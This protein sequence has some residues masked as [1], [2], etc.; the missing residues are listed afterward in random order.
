MDKKAFFL[1][2]QEEIVRC[3]PFP[4]RDDRSHSNRKKREKVE[5]NLIQPNPTQ[6]N[7]LDL[8]RD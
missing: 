2:G 3:S 4:R 6:P 7:P 8:A 5:S 1:I